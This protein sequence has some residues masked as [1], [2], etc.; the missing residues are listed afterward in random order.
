MTSPPVLFERVTQHLIP[1]KATPGER[2]GA[3]RTVSIA[4]TTDRS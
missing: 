2:P 4:P 1:K 3:A